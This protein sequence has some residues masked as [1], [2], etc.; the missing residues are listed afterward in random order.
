VHRTTLVTAAVLSPA[1]LSPISRAFAQQSNITISPFVSFLPTA[2]TSPL[3]GLALT[4]AGNGGFGLRA[5][6]HMAFR[7][8]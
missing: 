1:L 8:L 2:G 5:S 4:I 6:A 7:Q 3:A